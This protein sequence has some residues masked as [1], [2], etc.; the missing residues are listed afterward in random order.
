VKLTFADVDWDLQTVTVRARHA[1]NR[2]ERTIPIDDHCA[3][4]LVELREAAA[5]RPAGADQDLVFVNCLGRAIDNNLLRRFY[6]VCRRAGIPDACPG[7]AVDLHSLRV[8]YATLSL[9]GGANPKAV[10]SI[11]GHSTLDMTM[12]I[13]AK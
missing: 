1:K 7:G 11:L 2:R 5:D 12:G 10:Q 3:Q 9:E 8:T 4:M 13:Y 6:S